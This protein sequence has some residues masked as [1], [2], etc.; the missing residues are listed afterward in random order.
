MPAKASAACLGDAL[1]QSMGADDLFDRARRRLTPKASAIGSRIAEAHAAAAKRRSGPG[2]YGHAPRRVPVAGR[3]KW[4]T[5]A[6]G[7]YG[8]ARMPAP[9][10]RRGVFQARPKDPMTPTTHL[11]LIN[12]FIGDIQGGLG[13]FLGTWLAQQRQWSPSEIGSSPRSSRRR[14]A[15]ERALRALVDRVE[16]P[17]LLVVLS[18]AAILAGTLLLMPPT[19]SCRCWP[20]S[21]S[22]RAARCCCSP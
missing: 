17:R 11:A 9:R 20:R 14:P 18:C 4:K 1:L 7:R 15:A 12:V 5:G 6:F 10:E 16:R 13:P 22:R 19:A 8:R 2:A 21:S 3:C